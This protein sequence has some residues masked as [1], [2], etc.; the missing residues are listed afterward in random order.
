MWKCVYQYEK[1]NAEHGERNAVALHF[2]APES[3]QSQRSAAVN[4]YTV[5]ESVFSYYGCITLIIVLR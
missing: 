1:F 3:T 5:E 4:V 2:H